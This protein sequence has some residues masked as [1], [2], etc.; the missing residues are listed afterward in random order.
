[1]L[2]Y[3][4]LFFGELGAWATYLSEAQLCIIRAEEAPKENQE[5]PLWHVQSVPAK[6]IEEGDFVVNLGRVTQNLGFTVE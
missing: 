6:D 2:E 1:M 3:N 5:I 4:K